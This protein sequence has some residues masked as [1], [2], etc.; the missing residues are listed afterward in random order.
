MSANM[1]PNPGVALTFLPHDLRL[2]TMGVYEDQRVCPLH[3]CCP[4]AGSS[5]LVAWCRYRAD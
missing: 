3:G 5:K 4:I 1:A 2:S